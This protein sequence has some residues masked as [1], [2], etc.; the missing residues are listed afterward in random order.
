MGRKKRRDPFPEKSFDVFNISNNVE[1]KPLLS[2]AQNLDDCDCNSLEIGTVIASPNTKQAKKAS[3]SSKKKKRRKKQK[4]RYKER[5]RAQIQVLLSC[6]EVNEISDVQMVHPENLIDDDKMDENRIGEGDDSSTCT[7]IVSNVSLQNRDIHK[8]GET[9]EAFTEKGRRHN[10]HISFRTKWSVRN[11]DCYNDTLWRKQNEL[12][13]NWLNDMCWIG[14]EL[15]R[16][17]FT[18]AR[19]KTECQ[20]EKEEEKEKDIN[21]V[22]REQSSECSNMRSTMDSGVIESDEKY[23]DSL[24]ICTLLNTR[25]P[26]RKQNMFS[27]NLTEVSDH[28]IS[29]G[30]EMH[31]LSI[32]LHQ[33]KT[34]LWPAAIDC[35]KVMNE[36]KPPT[37]RDPFTPKDAFEMSR[38]ASNPFEEL[39]EGR[40]GGLNDMF[41]NRSAMK[42]VNI[43]AVLGFSLI[44]KS[45]DQYL[46]I[47]KRY[48]MEGF[49]SNSHLIP[50]RFVDLCGA[51]G[52]FTEYILEK[53]SKHQ[54]STQGWGLSL[55]G[56]NENGPGLDWKLK[57]LAMMKEANF[58]VCAGVDGTGDIL[59]WENV[60]DL[61]MQITLDCQETSSVDDQGIRN[62]DYDRIDFTLQN[63]QDSPDNNRVDLVVADGG[64]QAQRDSS[65]QEELTL[66]MVVSEIAAGLSILKPNGKLVIKTF[67]FQTLPTRFMLKFL[68]NHFEKLTVLKPILSRP[69]SAERYLV[70]YGFDGVGQNWDGL[71][72][73]DGIINL[74]EQESFNM[75]T[76]MDSTKTKNNFVFDDYFSSLD[77]DM[78]E[79]NVKSCFGI[80]SNLEKSQMNA[81]ETGF[82]S[83]HIPSKQLLDMNMYRKGWRLCSES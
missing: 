1:V 77:R 4:Q 79:L 82:T 54:I 27:V 5:K 9:F 43:D 48:D 26:K 42:L 33:I 3:S 31:A 19:S 69:A 21:H 73:R 80:L 18:Q 38:R 81:N 51:P 46:Q 41:I 76:N 83:M 52:G 47:S 2:A 36:N 23:M 32:Q 60:E 72:W 17:F 67:G 56:E 61:K 28:Q 66:T 53:C 15:G 30:E 7:D 24:E 57:H 78:L 25:A 39:G 45:P 58:R 65:R 22:R 10:K 75:Q 70:C 12:K 44:P 71:R 20:T 6:A 29:L 35:A 68:F 59:N 64:C 13:Y 40:K 11:S 62:A 8:G 34:R 55:I 74:Q 14:K 37:K 50:F 63:N 16:Q 49:L